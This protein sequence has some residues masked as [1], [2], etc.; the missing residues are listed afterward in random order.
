MADE[1]PQGQKVQLQFHYIKVPDY[2][3]IACH[4]VLGGPTPHGQLCMSL[5]SERAPIPRVVEYDLYGEPGQEVSFTEAERSPTRIE[6]RSGVIRNVHF[7]AYLTIE[8]ARQLHAWLG[9]QLNSID[10]TK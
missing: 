9:A 5:F 3:E 10:G 6:T 2:R 1:D 4:G 8:T 7:S